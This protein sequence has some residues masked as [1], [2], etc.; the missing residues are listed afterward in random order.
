VIARTE[1]GI[2]YRAARV[3]V[4]G[5]T[6]I[7]DG[8]V[9]VE[10][11]HI[12][13]VG[14]FRERADVA[15]VDLGDCTLLPGLIDAH[16]HLCWGSDVEPHRRVAEDGPVL[17]ALRSVAN[18]F[19]YLC[20]GV[21]TVRD[22]GSTDGVAVSLSEAVEDGVFPGPHI[23]AAGRAITMTGGHGSM[24]G[25][26]VDGP[27]AVRAA[28]RAELRAGA[29]CLKVMASGGVYGRRERTN[30]A[31]LRTTE[32]TAAVEEGHAAGVRI[33]AHAYSSETIMNAVNAGVD[34]I[35]HG[36]FLDEDAAAALIAHRVHLVNTLSVTREIAS[37]G[38][39][40]GASPFFIEK[41][42]EVAAAGVRAFQLAR[43]QGVLI[44]AGTD[45]GGAFQPHGS[46]VR[47]LETMVEYG[48]TPRE[49]IGYATEGSAAALGLQATRGALRA[50]MDADLFAV[51][52]DPAADIRAL[53]DVR[54]VVSRGHTAYSA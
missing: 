9:L 43:E 47:E 45:A 16:V 23:V 31:Q 29:G 18:L 10:G 39:E 32:M 53:R 51:R 42:A 14:Q 13:W 34:T 41:A 44:A 5:S 36:S 25:R 20:A 40:L 38:A 37:R 24:I 15:T 11:S 8:A 1:D 19:P 54:L 27:D 12:K 52:D 28:A 2:L 21:T 48:A 4:D 3:I 17:T 30:Q 35:E 26:E 22:L 33:A 7:M 49:A 50:G 46:L 6:T